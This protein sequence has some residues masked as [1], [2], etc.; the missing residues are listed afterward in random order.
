MNTAYPTWSLAWD[1]QTHDLQ[2][3][4]PDLNLRAAFDVDWEGAGPTN[5]SLVERTVSESAEGGECVTISSERFSCGPL[6]V[7]REVRYRADEPT[8][9]DVRLVVCN[10]GES[11]LKL[12]RLVPLLVK[13]SEGLTLGNKRAGD[14]VFYRNGRQKNDLPSVCVLGRNDLAY[15][16]AL[17]GLSET[18]KY[19]AAAE[20][21]SNEIISDELSVIV[22]STDSGPVSL[23]VGFIDAVRH[24]SE[25]RIR[26]D[27]SR[28]LDFLEA[29][30]LFDHVEL[31]PGESREGGW[32]R[33][34]AGEPFTAVERY[35]E[36]KRRATGSVAMHN[37]PSVFCTWY[38]YG[39]TVSQEDVYTNLEVLKQKDFPVDVVQV[40]EGWEQRFGNWDANHRFP[41]GMQ[42]VAQRIRNAGYRPGIWTAP[43][44]VE[45]RSDMRFYHDDWLLKDANGDP[46]LFYM[47]NTDNMV[48]DVTHPEVQAWIEG[49][50]RKLT[51]WG[52]TYHK[53]DFTRAV[54]LDGD[55]QYYNPKATRAEAYRMGIEAVRRGIGEDGYLLI[56][57]G[58]FSAPSGLVDAHRTS[59]D[60]LSMWSEWRGKQGGKVAPFTIKQ[61]VLRYWMNPLWHND[62]D[63]L[64]VRRRETK[65][66]SLDLS[67]GLLTEDEAR[68]TA[69]N[70]YWG[71][72]LNCFTEPMAEIDAD[73]IGLMRHL[74][75]STGIAALPRDMY[76]GNQY[77]AIF[78]TQ[79][80]RQAVDL[81]TWHTVSIVNWEDQAVPVSVRLDELLVGPFAGQHAS[82]T[83]AEFW[84]GKVVQGVGYGD[85]LDL[86]QLPPHASFHL[87]ITPE[88]DDVPMI[89][90]SDGHFSMGGTEITQFTILE[91][92]VEVGI[93]WP[94]DEPLTLHLSTP[95]GAVWEEGQSDESV[96][97]QEGSLLRLTVQGKF[98][99]VVKLKLQ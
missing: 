65:F 23:L 44:L 91:K 38:Y 77:P 97:T 17:T 55:Y 87:R 34:D 11:A 66:R 33:L 64:M 7:I 83:V 40:D 30:C 92:E 72:G 2:W 4:G 85:S 9:M 88:V 22:G 62:P 84:T 16:D 52:Y 74:I 45:P 68:V 39:D 49:L 14:W 27:E 48:W 1:P 59:S 94:W 86:G 75:P 93:Q 50:Y 13:G 81:G 26:T 36:A 90:S 89:V 20:K 8:S 78:D 58:M 56:C 12:I 54:A 76:E 35:V 28:A 24:L 37:P 73:R 5:W 15:M 71:G 42:Q 29:S 18:G 69:L 98:T 95:D 43:F 63:A 46:V 53:L 6:E 80:D 57:G 82:F 25:F 32:L 3:K 47:N 60:V 10:H 41:D 31:A 21:L 99:G 70:Q 79:V 19:A 96:W 61:N 67:L 51:G